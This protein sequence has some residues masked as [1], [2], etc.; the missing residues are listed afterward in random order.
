MDTWPA[1]LPQSVHIDYNL[2]PRSGLLSQ[3]EQRNP[4]RNRAYPEWTGTFSMVITTAQLST[5]RT[6]YDTTINQSGDFE[7][8][9]LAD[10]GLE[11]HFARF[12]SSPSWRTS[13]AYGKWVL[14]LPLEIIASTY[15]GV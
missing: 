8:P 1:T 14:T 10:L 13:Q 9:W 3:T 4:T 12:A 6:F 11:F 7:C 15:Q 2:Q 5:F